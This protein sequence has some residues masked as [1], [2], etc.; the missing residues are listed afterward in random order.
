[1]ASNNEVTAFGDIPKSEEF[2]APVFVLMETMLNK[3]LP[4]LPN[5]VSRE[6]GPLVMVK[7]KISKLPNDTKI[8]T[9]ID[10]PLHLP[11]SLANAIGKDK[12]IISIKNISYMFERPVGFSKG[13]AEFAK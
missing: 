9:I 7:A 12:G 13:W 5:L 4:K 11:I 1:M 3:T 6:E 2:T 8:A 10:T